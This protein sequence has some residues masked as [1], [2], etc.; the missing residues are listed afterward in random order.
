[1]PQFSSKNR[2]YKAIKIKSIKP[3]LL[4]TSG[5]GNDKGNKQQQIGGVVR[6]GNKELSVMRSKEKRQFLSMARFTIPKQK[7]TEMPPK[8]LLIM[9]HNSEI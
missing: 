7:R 5:K 8:L 2:R 4:L 6:F 1:M 3:L 9:L